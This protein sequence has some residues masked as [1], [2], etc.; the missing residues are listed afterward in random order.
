MSVR[1]SKTA[2]A[3]F[4]CRYIDADRIW[5]PGNFQCAKRLLDQRR[6]FGTKPSV[7]SVLIATRNGVRTG[8]YARGL[9]VAR[10]NDAIG[11]PH[12]SQSNQQ[13]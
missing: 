10:T 1:A 6:A 3:G 9:S 13:P 5:E 8:A 12:G 2:D 11:L 4:P 7:F